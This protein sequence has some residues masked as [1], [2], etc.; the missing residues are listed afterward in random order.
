M[1]NVRAKWVHKFPYE[2]GDAPRALSLAARA[3]VCSMCDVTA[4]LDSVARSSK[5][6]ADGGLTCGED[7]ADIVSDA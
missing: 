5:A 4:G 3:S 6:S 7:T 1:A 2:A